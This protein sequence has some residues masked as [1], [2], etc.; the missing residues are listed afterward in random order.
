MAAFTHPLEEIIKM[1]FPE[2]LSYEEA[3][4][5]YETLQQACHAQLAQLAGD[6]PLTHIHSEQVSLEL[7]DAATGRLV[8][9]VLPLT[10]DEN[11]LALRLIGET[12]EGQPAE[13]VFFS[14]LTRQKLPD[15]FGFGP[16]ADSCGNH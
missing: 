4:E 6:T 5:R 16:D 11:H 15:L 13:I 8:Q 3:R 7:T 14:D 1:I 2:N 10:V 12:I 9:R